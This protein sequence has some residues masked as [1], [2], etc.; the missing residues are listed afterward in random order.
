MEGRSQAARVPGRGRTFCSS[1]SSSKHG[2]QKLFL[3][4]PATCVQPPPQLRVCIFYTQAAAGQADFST[5]AAP[6]ADD[7]VTVTVDGKAVLVPRNISV[8]QARCS[9]KP[10]VRPPCWPSQGCIA[11][12]RGAWAPAANVALSAPLIS[13]APLLFSLRCGSVL[14]AAFMS[15]Y[16]WP[17]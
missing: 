13:S 6:P 5:P 3:F 1:S 7:R 12:W 14:P 17:C 16:V 8:L 2:H 4:I 11:A 15:E 10:C 9:G